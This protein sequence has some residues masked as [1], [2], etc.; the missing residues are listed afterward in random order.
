QHAQ[1]ALEQ[2][3]ESKEKA[4][5]HRET[6]TKAPK[7]PVK[8]KGY[9]K[10]KTDGQT[11]NSS[12]EPRK[13]SYKAPKQGAGSHSS[14][15]AKP[16][17]KPSAAVV[18]Q[19][20][21]QASELLVGNQALVKLGKEPMPVTITDIGKDGISVQLKSGMTVKVQQ[22]QLFSSKKAAN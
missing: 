5:K 8:H 10:S 18:P 3:K 16:A 2:L 17:N 9:S 11:D 4:A 14:K 7:N 19:V 12:N 1:H 21:I 13:G 15:G 22:T 20:P 6:N